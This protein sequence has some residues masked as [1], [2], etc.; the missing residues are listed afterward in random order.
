M[1]FELRTARLALRPFLA[2]DFDDLHSM[3]GDDRVMQ[4]IGSGLPGRTR[5]ESEAALERI[6]AF[7]ARRPGYG[8][9]HGS[10]RD[11]G[12][13]VGGCGLFPLPESDDIEIAYRMPF[14]CWGQG[15]GTEMA[16]AVLAHAFTTLNLDRVVGVTHLENAA[17]QGVLRKIGMR[18][19][20]TGMHFGRL[21]REFAVTR[22]A[23][24]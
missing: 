21:M 12:R 5:A 11:D 13:F 20:D 19:G 2:G 6:I 22:P 3:D 16:T 4:F 10:R 9:L 8:L 1:T 23:V 18:E 14:A 17:S 15:Y 7:G 24:S